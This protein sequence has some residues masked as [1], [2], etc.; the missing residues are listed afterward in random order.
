MEIEAVR[1]RFQA[2][3]FATQAAGA[4]IDEVGEGYAKCSLT[5][6]EIHCNAIG[7]VMGGVAFTLA[8]FAF[9][10][11]ANAGTEPTVSLSSHISFLSAVKGDR[12]I[13]EARRIRE[14]RCVCFYEVDVTDDLGTF[15]AKVS[16]TGYHLQKG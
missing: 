4:V 8:D 2:D 1:A 15:V 12:L 3:R 5:L 7:A 11:A 13:A 6:C 14:G 16:M 9:A 10:V